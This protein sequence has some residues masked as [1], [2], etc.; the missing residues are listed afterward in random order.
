MVIDHEDGNERSKRAVGKFV[1]TVGG[2]YDGVFRNWA[3]IGDVITD[4]HRY[5]VTREQYRRTTSE[6]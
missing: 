3:P 4:H 2:Q 6:K 5:T 1:E